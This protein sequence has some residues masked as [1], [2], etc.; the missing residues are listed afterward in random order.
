[1]THS[2]QRT[3]AASVNQG[4]VPEEVTVCGVIVENLVE[5]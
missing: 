1:L 5:V 4:S 3:P 2:N